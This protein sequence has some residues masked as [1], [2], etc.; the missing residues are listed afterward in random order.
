MC[1]VRVSSGLAE[2]APRAPH[3]SGDADVRPAAWELLAAHVDTLRESV[4]PADVNRVRYHIKHDIP[5]NYD[6]DASAFAAAFLTSN[7][8][9]ASAALAVARPTSLRRIADLGSGSGAAGLAALAYAAECG[10]EGD[11]E[12]AFVDTSDSQLAA[13]EDALLSVLPALSS[14][15]IHSTYIREDV[16]KWSCDHEQWAGLALS[17]H[18]LVESPG[19]AAEVTRH[20]IRSVQPG[21][22]LLIVERADDDAVCRQ[23]A[24]VASQSAL[25]FNRHADCANVPGE[26]D[27]GP[28]GLQWVSIGQPSVDWFPE[29]IVRYFE[30]WN[31]RDPDLLADVFTPDATYSEKPAEE[32]LQGLDRIRTYWVQEVRPQEYVDAQPTAVAYYGYRSIVEWRSTFHKRDLDYRIYGSMVL[33]AEPSL[34]RIVSLREIFR[35]SKHPT[36]AGS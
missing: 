6:L 10:V 25:P 22:M 19:T 14:L 21:G 11:V 31:K 5:L 4:A 33:D 17:S 32:A 9:K 2:Q 7:F 3:A 20:A 12:I 36:A 26:G 8:W 16:T 23:A 18:L 35:V 30:A 1:T 27:R 34:Q 29:L 28:M 13:A 24:D 15:R